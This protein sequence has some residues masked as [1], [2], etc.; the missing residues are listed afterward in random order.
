MKIISE[1]TKQ[2]QELKTICITHV[3]S[4]SGIAGAFAKL[5]TWATANNLWTKSPKMSGVYLDDPSS[6]PED[7]LRSKACLENLSDVELSEGMETYNISGGKYFVM[8]FELTMAEYG[9][10]WQK[11]YT[12]FNERGYQYDTR[13]HYELYVSCAGD[14]QNADAPWVV[15]M[16]IP[17]K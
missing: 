2:Q 17:M 11:A 15:D 7:K 12:T 5:C 16:C 14:P 1:E 8:Q 3:G 10:A 4:Y 6:T 9:E 13:D